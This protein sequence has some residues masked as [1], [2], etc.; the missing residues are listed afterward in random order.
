[1]K[2]RI[3][4]MAAKMKHYDYLF[5]LMLAERSLKHKQI[6]LVKQCGPQLCEQLRH[7]ECPSRR[8]T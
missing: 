5:G 7:I 6:N 2:A 3:N 8:L 4:G 1:M